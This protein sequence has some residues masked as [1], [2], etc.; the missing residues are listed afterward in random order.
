[1]MAGAAQKI[2]LADQ[3]AA[4]RD[5]ANMAAA[6]AEYHKD[7]DKAAHAVMS[8]RA[9]KLDAAAASLAWLRDNADVVREAARAAAQKAKAAP[10]ERRRFSDLP[11]ATQAAMRCADVRFQRF[12]NA[13]D[14]DYAAIAVRLACGVESRK[15]LDTVAEAG[16]AWRKIDGEFAAWLRAEGDETGDAGE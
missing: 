11:L 13:P 1:M 12:L 16:A 2:P 10:A 4:V 15:E 3:A 14:A 8:E 7:R 9:K 6:T 5:S